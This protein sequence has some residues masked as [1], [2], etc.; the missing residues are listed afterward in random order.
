MTY[1]SKI[2]Q[3][4][5]DKNKFLTSYVIDEI[6]FDKSANEK[7]I[8]TNWINMIKRMGPKIIVSWGLSKF[9]YP[10][11]TTRSTKL[12]VSGLLDL[13]DIKHIYLI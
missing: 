12:G 8:I 5:Q 7:S 6:N 3:Y 10:Y 4:L 11:L 1:Y 2:R 13:E 9:D